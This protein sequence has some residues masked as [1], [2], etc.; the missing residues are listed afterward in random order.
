VARALV[1]TALSAATAALLSV[2]APSSARADDAGAWLWFETRVPLAGRPA[3]LPRLS[4]R[5]WSDTRLSKNAGGL[6]QQFLRT[7][8]VFDVTRWLV[9]AVHGTIY[10]DRLPDGRFAQEARL[11]VEPTFQYRFGPLVVA[12]RNRLEYRWR[13]EHAR[14]RYRNLIRV[15]FWPARWPAYPFVWNELFVD[16]TVGYNENRF[17][18]GVGIP[19]GK[20]RHRLEL[21]YLLRM[22]KAEPEWTRDHLALT[23]LFVGF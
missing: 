21:A 14:V 20:G 19:F 18:S 6:A 12:D 9:L 17:A 1:I 23:S 3:S 7:G 5:I 11:E 4:W 8:P 13:S 15:S 10:A 2:A 16:F 22:R